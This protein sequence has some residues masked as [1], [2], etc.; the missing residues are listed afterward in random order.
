MAKPKPSTKAVAVT[1]RP[2]RPSDINQ[3]AHQLVNESTMEKEPP[4]VAIEPTKA[5]ISLVMASLGRKGGRIGGKRRLVT[6]TQEARSQIGFKAAQARW[7][8]KSK[9]TT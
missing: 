6:M 1:K 7:A 4:S 5:E 8:N 9:K 2:K 3:L